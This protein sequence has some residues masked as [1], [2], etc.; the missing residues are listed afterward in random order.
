MNAGFKRL[1]KI[2][3][4]QWGHVSAHVF[5]FHAGRSTFIFSIVRGVHWFYQ[6]I[7]GVKQAYCIVSLHPSLTI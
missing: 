3:E 6:D 5:F 4:I 2:P 7:Q 1:L